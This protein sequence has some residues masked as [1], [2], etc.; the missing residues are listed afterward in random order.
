MPTAK[1]AHPRGCIVKSDGRVTLAVLL[2]KKA[3]ALTT[4]NRRAQ[5]QCST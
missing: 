5:L 3:G 4:G 2:K 1:M